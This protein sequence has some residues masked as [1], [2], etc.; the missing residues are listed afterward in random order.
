MIKYVFPIILLFIQVILFV[1][2]KGQLFLCIVPIILIV[3]SFIIAV[4]CYQNVVNLITSTPIY[5]HVLFSIWMYII[6]FI[7]ST[8]LFIRC[9]FSRNKKRKQKIL[10]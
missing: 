4:D 10:D 8:I 7:I 9:L 5:G 6:A 3:S 1:N 2:K